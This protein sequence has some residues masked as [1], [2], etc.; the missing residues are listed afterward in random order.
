MTVAYPDS[1][2]CPTTPKPTPTSV[3]GAFGVY[4]VYH[5]VIYLY[6]ALFCCGYNVSHNWRHGKYLP[7]LFRVALLVLLLSSFDCILS[8]MSKRAC[9]RTTAK[10]RRTVFII[11]AM[12]CGLFLDTVPDHHQGAYLDLRGVTKYLCPYPLF[13]KFFRMIKTLV[14]CSLPGS[15]L[16]GVTAAQPCWYLLNMKVIWNICRIILWY[17]K[18]SLQRN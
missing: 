6:C 3:N 4:F 14:S 1:G 5:T 7:I 12:Y 11:I 15:Y 16:K 13:S 8:D 9:H 10:Q 18:F 2:S 17:Y